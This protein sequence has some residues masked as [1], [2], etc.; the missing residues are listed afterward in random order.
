M[1]PR[2]IVDGH[3][4]LEKVWAQ[5]AKEILISVYVPEAEQMSYE[6]ALQL[7]IERDHKAA[8]QLVEDFKSEGEDENDQSVD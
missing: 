6:D 8:E 2:I 5:V 3:Q 1:K 7:A 4:T